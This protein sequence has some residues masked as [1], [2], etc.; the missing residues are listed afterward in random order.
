MLTPWMTD[1]GGKNRVV[2][3]EINLKFVYINHNSGTHQS[4]LKVARFIGEHLGEFKKAYGSITIEKGTPITK[5]L[6]YH[7]D[8]VNHFLQSSVTHKSTWVYRM[9]RA[10]WPT[11]GAYSSINLEQKI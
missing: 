1:S 3:Q 11:S 6:F 9:F 5:R 7:K 2:V 10:I 8:L 4:L